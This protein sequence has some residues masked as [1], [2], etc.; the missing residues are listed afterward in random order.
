MEPESEP[1]EPRRTATSG[2][3]QTDP[4]CALALLDT[5]DDVDLEDFAI[6]QNCISGPGTPAD[7]DCRVIGD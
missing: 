5:D 7:P 4:A 6:F 2:N 1:E 3:Y